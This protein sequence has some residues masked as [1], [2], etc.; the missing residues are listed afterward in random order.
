LRKLVGEWAATEVAPGRLFPWLA[1]SFGAGIVLYFAA[2]REPAL[3]AILPLAAFAI[4]VAYL[5]R[6]SAFGFPLTLACACLASGFAVATLNAARLAHPVLSIPV[7]SITLNGFVEVREER[8]R[9]DRIVV[10][11]NRLDG[12]IRGEVPERVR[13][14]CARI[15]RPRSAHSSP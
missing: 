11:I 5:A 15:P 10:H 13:V 12:R 2:D 4:A 6:R 7:S 14:P 9:S 3:W 1:V 8:E